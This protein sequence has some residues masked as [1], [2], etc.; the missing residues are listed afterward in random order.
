MAVGADTL[1]ANRSPG[2]AIPGVVIRLLAAVAL[3][4]LGAAK[5]AA[6]KESQIEKGYDDLDPAENRGIAGD[7]LHHAPVRRRRGG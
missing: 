2:F 5:L 6:R 1:G 4:G 3:R 7:R